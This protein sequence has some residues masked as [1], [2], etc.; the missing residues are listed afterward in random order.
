LIGRAL[1]VVLALAAS[2]LAPTAAAERDAAATAA[3]LAKQLRKHGGPEGG[4][5][6]AMKG[7]F[8]CFPDDPQSFITLFGT[9]GALVADH[10][11]HLELFFAAR[12]AIGERKWSAKAVAVLAS[13]EPRPAAVVLYGELLALQLEARPPAVL[14][15]A[16]KL[17]G[18]TL[19][20]FWLALQAGPVG[21]RVA[22]EVCAARAAHRACAAR[23]LPP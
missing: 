3:C 18:I 21:T 14:D 2:L 1:G 17:D 7:H 9:Q 12:P 8:E 11:A 22:A 5:A 15:A 4:R 10:S 19:A 16:A 23:A 20:E 6:S 13:G